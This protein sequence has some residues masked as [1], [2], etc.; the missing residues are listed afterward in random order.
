MIEDTSR[1]AFGP[2]IERAQT[3]SLSLNADPAAFFALE[4]AC[5]D[6]LAQI[7]RIQQLLR[8]IYEHE[9]WGLGERSE[10]LTSAQIL[11]RRFREKAMNGPNNAFD[12]LAGHYRAVSDLQTL[13]RTI[14]ASY[15]ET[16]AEFAAR[17]R[18]LQL[19]QQTEGNGNQ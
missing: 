10:V 3:G 6:S 5:A 8:G 19:D 14:R 13:F 11:V 16:D 15:E 18:Q 17:F 9:S 1:V 2:L 12:T 4:Q 7:E